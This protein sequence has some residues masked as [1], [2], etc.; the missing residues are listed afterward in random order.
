MLRG[1]FIFA[2][3]TLL[4]LTLLQLSENLVSYTKNKL[5]RV[6][7]IPHMSSVSS[8]T[9][10]ITLVYGTTILS[11]VGLSLTQERWQVLDNGHLPIVAIITTLL[12]ALTLRWVYV[13]RATL[14]QHTMLVPT[15]FMTIIG[16]TALSLLSWRSLNALL[17]TSAPQSCDTQIINLS[18]N[19]YSGRRRK[20]LAD[21][22]ACGPFAQL[23]SV[24]IGADTYEQ[25]EPQD[26][27]RLV[28]RQ[29]ALRSPWA[30]QEAI[31]KR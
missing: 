26:A 7:T 2:C 20:Y 29:G 4:Q 10:L 31:E 13:E 23:L 19:R 24:R 9:I 17:D 1:S 3:I 12:S 14:Q 11:A 8:S 30:T 6:R 15:I 22:Q 21:L 28:Y 27:V 25:L 16:A 18:S 5:I